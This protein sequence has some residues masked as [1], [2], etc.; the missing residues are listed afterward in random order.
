MP[1]DTS[2]VSGLVALHNSLY[3]Y[4]STAEPQLKVRTAVKSANRGRYIR[5]GSTTEPQLSIR[6]ADLPPPQ[7]Q[8]QSST[9]DWCRL[10]L[11]FT[12]PNLT[13]H[14]LTQL[15]ER[16]SRLA[17]C[18]PPSY[19]HGWLLVGRRRLCLHTSVAFTL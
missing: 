13:S 10:P 5:Y 9:E 18:L 11:I 2:L 12:V 6:V 4:A 14:D 7:L 15:E 1:P 19:L 3:K 16:T 8:L 17:P